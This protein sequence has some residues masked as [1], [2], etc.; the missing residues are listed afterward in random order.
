MASDMTRRRN[1]PLGIDEAELGESLRR[2]R[3]A[4]ARLLDVDA[5]EVALAPNTSFGVNLGAALAATRSPGT[6]VVSEGEFPANVYPWMNLRPR[7]FDVEIVPADPLGRPEPERL[8]ERLQ[9]DDVRVLA[10]S[11]VQFASGYRADLEAFGRICRERDIL[12]VV[13]AIQ[14]L[15]AVP[16]RPREA[17][18]D[19]LAS[20]AQKWLCSPWGSGFAWIAER[21]LEAFDPPM[22]SWLS[23]E[24]AL[25][26]SDVLPYRWGFVDDARKFELAT[27]GVQDHLGC[28]LALE[29]FLEVGVGRIREHLLGLQEPLLAWIEGRDDVTLVTPADP[30]RRAGI[31]AFRTADV[32]RTAARLRKGGVVLSVRE[33]SIRL[34][35]H[36]YN[37]ADEMERVLEILRRE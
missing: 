4:V 21:H 37:T 10:L 26:F 11:A 34:S 23:V 22:V 9:G 27:L 7:G 14:A 5:D 31:V 19:I 33:G 30:A 32:E 8:V 29:L 36:F 13:D 35:P 20:G 25:D 18:V 16:L 24:S 2:C 17:G 1:R 28:A 15:G 3:S 6:I 12:F